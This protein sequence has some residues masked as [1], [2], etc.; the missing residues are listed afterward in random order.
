MVSLSWFAASRRS[1]LGSI[2]KFRGVWPWVGV[3]PVGVSRPVC[4]STENRAMLSC[5]R[6][7]PYT[8]L[9]SA[10]TWISEQVV[11]PSYPSGSVDTVWMGLSV[12]RSAS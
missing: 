7:E 5:P 1:P 9:P 10:D 4:W 3:W 2:P 6:L 8:N 12:P 11:E